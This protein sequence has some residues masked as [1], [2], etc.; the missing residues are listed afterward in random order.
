MRMER[1]EGTGRGARRDAG[2]AGHLTERAW[3]DAAFRHIARNNVD[4][5]RVEE[6]ARELKVTKGS[7]YWHFRNRQHLVER[8]LEHWMDRATVQVT[9]WARAEDR[10][11]VE[12]LR[13]LLSLPAATPPDKHGADIEL[14][15]RSWARRETLAA[16][17]VAA[18]DRIRRDFFLELMAELGFSGED[19]ARRAAIA[20]AFMLGESLLKTGGSKQE[21]FAIVEACAAMLAGGA[22]GGGWGR[23]G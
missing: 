17:T 4:D 12:R 20:Q 5:I 9:R 18:V 23:D 10:S 1:P 13:R 14:A 22:G 15:I 7:F 19:A 2:E 8:V 11:G 3:I 6:L 16:E 21:R